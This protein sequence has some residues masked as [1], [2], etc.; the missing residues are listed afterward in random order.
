[1]YKHGH[2]PAIGPSSTYRTWQQMIERCTNPKRTYYSRYGGRGIMVCDAWLHSFAAFLADM[3]ARPSGA[4]LDRVNNDGNYESG[5][6]RWATKKEQ[7]RNNSRNVVISYR[8]ESRTL[9][10]WCE[11]LGLPYKTIKARISPYGW[12]PIAALTTPV[13]LKEA[14][15]TQCPQGHPYNEENTRLEVGGSRKCRV[16]D[17]QRQMTK[18]RHAEA[19]DG[20]IARA[21]AVIAADLSLL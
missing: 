10:E 20:D 21:K 19:I 15:R 8:N 5:N 12:D 9:I 18:R 14:E 17:R 3:G 7:S 2:S 1:M 11:V 13:E 6:C 4:T 16:C